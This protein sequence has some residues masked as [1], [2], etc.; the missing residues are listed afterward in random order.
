MGQMPQA[1]QLSTSPHTTTKRHLC[2]LEPTCITCVQV[3]RG[4]LQSRV[5]S[6][7]PGGSWARLYKKHCFRLAVQRVGVDP[8]EQV[9]CSRKHRRGEGIHGE[10][11]A[12]QLQPVRRTALFGTASHVWQDSRTCGNAIL[13]DDS[14]CSKRSVLHACISRKAGM[15]VVRGGQ[16][17]VGTY[18][19]AAGWQVGPIRS[20]TW[21]V[22]TSWQDE[23]GLPVQLM[24]SPQVLPQP[25]HGA[26]TE[27]GTGRSQRR[28]AG[29]GTAAGD[30]ARERQSVQKEEGG[31]PTR[32]C[33]RT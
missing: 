6:N 5:R 10:H 8:G 30:R 25:R 16:P 13:Q 27:L 32:T 3:P 20:S 23:G 1:P 28:G 4:T 31:A 24:A 26:A 29:Q 33:R 15:A 22:C 14:S 18:N 9:E 21:R 17:Q 2:F 12:Q 7:S 11:K 19:S